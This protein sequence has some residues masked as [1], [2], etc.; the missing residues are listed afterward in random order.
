MINLGDL[1]LRHLAVALADAGPFAEAT[2]RAIIRVG[3]EAAYRNSREAAPVKTGYLR[4]TIYVEY[5]ND[6]LGYEVGATADY[7][8]APTEV[9][10]L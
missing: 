10:G 5:D 6:G 8:G 3:G 2:A 7:A 9:E 4:S 1:E